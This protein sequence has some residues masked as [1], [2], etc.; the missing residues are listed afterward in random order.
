MLQKWGE[1]DESRSNWQNMYGT[2]LNLLIDLAKENEVL[3]SY[4]LYQI[5]DRPHSIKSILVESL[6]RFCQKLC[7]IINLN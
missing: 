7:W 3:A 4:N 6:Q 1:V 2:R 5:Q